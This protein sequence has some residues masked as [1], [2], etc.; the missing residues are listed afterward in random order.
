MASERL[1]GRGNNVS[2]E[3]LPRLVQ[4]VDRKGPVYV[5]VLSGTY[6]EGLKD[7][8]ALSRPRVRVLADLF[9]SYTRFTAVRGARI[10]QLHFSRSPVIF[11]S[12]D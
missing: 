10:F 5:L 9:H 6:L 1:V 3:N 11:P 2:R 4:R 7:Q 8:T 12:L